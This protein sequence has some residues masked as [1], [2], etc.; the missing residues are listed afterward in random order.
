MNFL[1]LSMELTLKFST[2]K[3]TCCRKCKNELQAEYDKKMCS[4]CLAREKERDTLWRRKRKFEEM[5]NI[6]PGA[7]PAE[8]ARKELQITKVASGSGPALLLK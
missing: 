1:T 8:V 7:L 2:S 4:A 3:P 5:K 6:V